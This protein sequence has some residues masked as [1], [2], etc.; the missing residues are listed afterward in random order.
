[1]RN[2]WKFVFS[3]YISTYTRASILHL[4]HL[5]YDPLL[6]EFEDP[7]AILFKRKRTRLPGFH[8]FLTPGKQLRLTSSRLVLPDDSRLSSKVTS[9]KRSP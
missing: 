5:L 4:D 1:M 9:S 8:T 6:K 2:L 7:R 3:C